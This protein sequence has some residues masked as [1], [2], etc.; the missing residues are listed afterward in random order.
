MSLFLCPVVKKNND[1]ISRTD[2]FNSKKVVEFKTKA[3]GNT[4]FKYSDIV[5]RHT[6][7][8][9]Y[10]TELSRPAFEALARE[11]DNEPF[12]WLN[13][14][15]NEAWRDCNEMRKIAVDFIAKAI[16]IGTYHS[17]LHVAEG[18][19]RLVKYRVSHTPTEISQAASLSISLSPSE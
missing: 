9:I 7:P 3:S 2:L 15:K 1:T 19:W 4:V 10:E 8:D 16:L 13:V 6:P 11:A 17:D 14:I 18:G 12:I 5:D